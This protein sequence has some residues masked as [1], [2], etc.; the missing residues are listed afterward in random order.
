MS[1]RPGTDSTGRPSVPLRALRGTADS[2]TFN[3]LV[4]CSSFE[5][6]DRWLLTYLKNFG[7]VIPLGSGISFAIK[8]WWKKM[9]TLRDALNSV[10]LAA[11]YRGCWE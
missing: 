6:T 4:V 5:T 10:P 3:Q 9:G 7:D 2:G 8:K 1:P 11:Q